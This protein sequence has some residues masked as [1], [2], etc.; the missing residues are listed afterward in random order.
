MVWMAGVI[1][2][3]VATQ[4]SLLPR[5]SQ[6]WT[7]L[8]AAPGFIFGVVWRRARR[9]ILS[10]A[11]SFHYWHSVGNRLLTVASNVVTNIN[12]S[13]METCYKIFRRELNSSRFRS[14]KIASVSSRRSPSRSPSPV[15]ASTRS[16]LSLRRAQCTPRARRSAGR[17]G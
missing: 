15:R 17:T 1:V 4:R 2:A 13:D 8:A 16:A 5:T 12:L 10:V 9:A 3:V 11:P 6:W 7:L 14:K